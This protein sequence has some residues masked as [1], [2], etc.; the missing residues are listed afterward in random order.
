MAAL[1]WALAS[2][3]STGLSV[4]GGGPPDETAHLTLHGVAAAEL[5]RAPAALVDVDRAAHGPAGHDIELEDRTG[6]PGRLLP[7]SS[8]AFVP[9]ASAAITVGTGSTASPLATDPAPPPGPVD[10][11]P[12]GASAPP[13]GAG[14]TARTPA[15][16]IPAPPPGAGVAA[17]GAGYAWPM[18]PAPAVVTPFR[19]PSHPYGPGHR[20][21]DLSGAP[22]APVL[23]ARAGTVVFAG[24]VGGRDLVSVLHDDGLRTTYEPVLPVVETGAVIRAGEVIG[25][26]QPGHAGCAAQACLHWGVRRARTEYLDPLVLL[27]PLRV[28]LLPV[29]VPWPQG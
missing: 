20:G 6:T 8:L 4:A 12:A 16:G 23:A 19:A 25:L 21:V 15:A 5:A 14:S 7:G 1:A 26:L 18:L 28:R 10:V 11:P 9:V 27:R 3:L 29:P 2:A 24:P 17:P 13:A 22:G